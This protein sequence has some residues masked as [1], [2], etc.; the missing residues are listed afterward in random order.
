M[1]VAGW[2][3]WAQPPRLPVAIKPPPAHR[4]R[5]LRPAR[6]ER[7]RR[8]AGETDARGC[9]PTRG[10]PLVV[11]FHGGGFRLGDKSSVPGLAGREVPGRGD[12]GGLGELSAVAGRRVPRPDAR[13]CA[14]DPVPPA[15]RAELGID[16]HRIAASGSSAGAGIALWVGFHDDLADPRSPDPV[17]RGSRAGVA[18][19]GVNG[20]QT[21]YDPRF[22]KRVIGGRAHEHSAL[23]PF[24]GLPDSDLGTPRAHQLYED[25]SPINHA[26]SGDPPVILFYAEPDE[27]LPAD[28]RAG[29]GIHHPRFGA[30][31]KAKLD[32]M[33]VECVVRHARD[34]PERDDPEEAEFREMTAFFL[35]HLRR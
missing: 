19:L 2:R 30:A 7:A 28:A 16:P 6:T 35:R 31:L 18:C 1:L 9:R 26:S 14:G 34:F 13:R 15:A 24:Y 17:A 23:K 20:A 8:L 33:G 29:Q 11:F 32:P 21:S 4:E 10:A 25:A 3:A 12:L 22:I 27:P 5:P